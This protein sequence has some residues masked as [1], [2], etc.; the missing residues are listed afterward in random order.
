[1]TAAGTFALDTNTYQAAYTNLT[2]IGSLANAAGWLHNDGSGNFAYSTPG[3]GAVTSLTTTGNPGPATLVGG[4]LNIPTGVNWFGTGNSN[5][6]GS[7]PTS[8]SGIQNTAVGNG[9]LA[10]LTSGN[11]NVAVGLAA[12][13]N[14]TTGYQN[15]AIGPSALFQETT[16]TTNV[17]IGPGALSN[18]NG[19]SD[20]IAIGQATLDSVTTGDDNVGMGDNDLMDVTTGSGNTAIGHQAGEIITTGNFNLYLGDGASPNIGGTN[21]EFETVIGGTNGHGSNTQTL[22]ISTQS[23]YIPGLAPSSGGPD[24]LQIATTG[25]ITNTGSGCGAG[26]GTVTSFAAPSAS[27]P[28]WLVPTVTNATSTPSLAVAASTIPVAAGGTGTTTPGLVAGTGILVANTWPNQTI[29]NSQGGATANVLGYGALPD[30]E[31]YKKGQ[32]AIFSFTS[33]SNVVNFT[34]GTGGFSYTFTSADVGKYISFWPGATPPFTTGSPYVARITAVNSATQFVISISGSNVQTTTAYGQW[35]TDLAGP[36]QACLDDQ[37]SRTGGLCTIPAGNYLMAT[38]PHYILAGASDDGSY[39]QPAGGS[40]A[41][42]SCSISSGSLTTCSVSA[43][44]S[45]YTKNSTLQTSISGGGGNSCY[46]F[47]DCGWAWVTA[48]TN[49]SGVVTSATV[50]YPGYGFTSA[51]TVTVVPLG[52]DGAT[53][54][55]TETGGTMN[56]PV[57]TSGG[58]GYL[59][60]SSVEWDAIGGGC[61]GYKNWGGTITVATGTVATNS[62]GV[63]N[64]TVSVV[65]NATGCT[66]NPTIVIGGVAC[67]TGTLGSPVW[68]QCSNVAPLAPT[69]FPVHVVLTLGVSIRGAAGDVS[70]D[71]ATILNS[72]WDGATIDNNEPIMFGGAIQGQDIGNLGLYNGFMGIMGTNNVNFS[73]IHDIAFNTG[74]GMWTDATDLYSQFINLAFYGYVP[75]ISGGTWSQRIDYP[76]IGGGFFDMALTQNIVAETSAYGGA[77]SIDQKYDDWFANYFWHPEFSGASVDFPETC[78]FPQSVSQRQTSHNFSYPTGSNVMCYRGVSSM[79]MAILSRTGAETGAGIW[80]GL[81]LKGGA[82]RSIIYGNLGGLQM[83]DFSAEGSVPITGSGDP[84]RNATT[85]E[86]QIIYSG[87][88]SDTGQDAI[89]NGVSTSYTSNVT[90][91]LWDIAN[92]G[93]PAGMAW[94]SVN[95]PG[96]STSTPR[97]SLDIQNQ[98][99]NPQGE[100]FT[101]NPGGQSTGIT[102]GNWSNATQST[103]QT[104]VIVGEIVGDGMNQGSYSAWDYNITNK[105]WSI[106]PDSFSVIAPFYVNNAV[107]IFQ[108][109]SGLP[110]SGKYCLD[111]GS[112]GQIYPTTTDCGSGGS[113]DTITS[114]N[115]T[116]TVGGSSSATT[117]DINFSHAN[118]WAAKQTWSALMAVSGN[119]TGSLPE[120]GWSGVPQTTTPYDPLQLFEPA[121][122]TDPTWNANG[123]FLGFNPATGFTGNIF[124]VRA[125]NGGASVAKLDYQGNLTVNSYNGYTPANCTA[126]TSGSDCLTL[127]SG[128]VP[129]GNLPGVGGGT[130]VATAW[131]CPNIG[132]IS[133]AAL[134]TSG[135]PVMIGCR[136]PFGATVNITSIMCYAD[137]GSASTTIAVTDGSGNN[138]LSASTCTCSNSGAGASC[139]LSG[140]YTTLGTGG[141]VNTTVVPDGTSK[142]VSVGITTTL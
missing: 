136:N 19:A 39:G 124:D 3:G 112:T 63:A 122:S 116:L 89:L 98:V 27:W 46:D 5:V 67:N 85:L 41:V 125:P 57:M 120:M 65:H 66:S 6:G 1:M 99:I 105:I 79:G 28:S 106:G 8:A 93:Y 31:P 130:H 97:Q 33:G 110:S 82:S 12:G 50:V 114:P 10:N 43:G 88:G 95:C 77:G 127:T 64:G 56:L 70:Q 113:G 139:G 91:C 48:S 20:N 61:N 34:G 111:I 69:K 96:S 18:Q 49:S 86:G 52:G 32:G 101:F 72:T 104:P 53:A 121:G 17:A 14:L 135:L 81:A 71:T 13:H 84:Y 138:L 94:F 35:G 100:L 115:S 103:P 16:G 123:T 137:N 107:A 25:Q 47:G 38:T 7:L 45:G 118:T 23:T 128:L 59:P 30:D 24:C 131:Q 11:G 36:L 132:L 108:G 119:G 117:L 140:T 76:T 90:Q 73:K 134:P 4:V 51:P 92:G 44:G 22:G 40:G 87:G 129:T 29:S 80:Q 78:K 58:S 37:A 74:F 26:A 83:S 60:S 42:L 21:N 133:N 15:V 109:L 55:A 2:S 142:E 62:S 54:T 141:Y 126:G 75:W 9:A 102:F 68:A